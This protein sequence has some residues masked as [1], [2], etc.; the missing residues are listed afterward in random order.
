[1]VP[2]DSNN[3]FAKIIRGEIPCHRV[4]EDEA[5]IA[6]L[7]IMPV[8]DG[9]C[10]VI[11]KMAARNIFDVQADELASLVKVARIVSLAAC[12]AFEADGHTLRLHSE[13]SGGQEVFHIHFHL[14]PMRTGV[15]PRPRAMADPAILADHA[16]RIRAAF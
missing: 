12:K 4:Y 3:I 13:A 5:T 10:L 15:T 6:F 7:D 16:A 11:P 9:H 2:Y 1:M 8:V 14:L